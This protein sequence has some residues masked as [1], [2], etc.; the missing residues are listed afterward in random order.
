MAFKIGSDTYLDNDSGV[1]FASGTSRPGSPVDGQVFFHSGY[2]RL[3]I[4]VNDDWYPVNKEV[5]WNP[6]FEASYTAPFIY[7]QIIT[8]SYVGGGYKS[9]SPYRNVNSMEH[10]TD[11]MAN[12]GDKFSHAASYISGACNKTK[13]FLWSAEG[14]HAGNSAQTASFNMWNE[15]QDTYGGSM[16]LQ[17]AR[18]DM[19]TI[20][21]EHYFAYVSMGG[22]N[23]VDIFNLTNETSLASNHGGSNS[24]QTGL[25]GGVQD[26]LKGYMWTDSNSSTTIF[27]FNTNTTNSDYSVSTGQSNIGFHGQQKGINS[28]I[29]KGYMGNEGSYNGGYNLRRITFSNNTNQGNVSK[30]IGNCGE[31]NFDMGQSWQYMMGMYDGL[32]NNRGWKFNYTTDSGHELGT[33]SVRTG[34]PGGSSGH[35]F[36]RE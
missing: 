7:R 28:K 31:E 5:A 10:A 3:E 9:S 1:R 32:Q 20:Q 26:E 2:N 24:G 25:A 12:L 36:W 21:Q 30:P 11:M 27:T 16:N 18:N 8:K 23:Y 4:Y 15:T 22:S 6:Q 17:A 35:C 33:G 13:A 34:I 14:S 19:A 29:G